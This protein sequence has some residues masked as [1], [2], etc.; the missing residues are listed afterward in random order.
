MG[1]LALT[2]DGRHIRFPVVV[3]RQEL[4]GG[5]EIPLASLA[6]WYHIYRVHNP[7]RAVLVRAHLD[8]ATIERAARD[9]SIG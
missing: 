2:I 7:D 4:V 3:E 6:H 9:L 1:G 8:E 5:V